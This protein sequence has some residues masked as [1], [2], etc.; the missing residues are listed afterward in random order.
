M[1]PHQAWIVHSTPGRTRLQVPALRGHWRGLE[2]VAERLGQIDALESVSANP[3]TGS[4]VLIH[5]PEWSMVAER[6]EH[7]GVLHIEGPAA[8]MMPLSKWVDDV[9]ERWNASV[10]RNTSG[11]LDLGSLGFVTMMGA[12]IFQ[13]ARG[14]VLG[15]ASNLFFLG[16]SSLTMSRRKSAGLRGS[17]QQQGE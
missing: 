4:L 15:P 8:E 2:L 17:S 6:I 16:L 1:S 14:Q 7:T 12:T 13:L 11:S 5:K 9:A 10:R 3:A